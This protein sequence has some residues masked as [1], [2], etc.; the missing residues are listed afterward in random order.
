MGA[1]FRGFAS[2]FAVLVCLGPA[3]TRQ[4]ES[5]PDDKLSRFSDLV[6]VVREISTFDAPGNIAAKLPK[7]RDYLKPVLTTLEVLHVLKGTHTD[8]KLVILHN[9][10]DLRGRMLANGPILVE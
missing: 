8:R 6:V 1:D 2:V 9:R 10:L 5:W 7:D 3:Q 4:I